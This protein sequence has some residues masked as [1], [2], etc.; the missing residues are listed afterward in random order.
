MI[1]TG[2][3]DRRCC[4]E[5]R[6]NALVPPFTS[7][8][9]RAQ[10]KV[11]SLCVLESFSRLRLSSCTNAIHRGLTSSTTAGK[12]HSVYYQRVKGRVVAR[13]RNQSIQDPSFPLFSHD[14][15]GADVSGKVGEV[16]GPHWSPFVFLGVMPVVAW[17]VL[18]TIRPDLR[19]RFLEDIQWVKSNVLPAAPVSIQEQTGSDLIQNT[20]STKDGSKAH[21]PD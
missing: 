4:H 6:Q 2:S 12:Q 14:S 3:Y 9:S 15:P 16:L 11:F 19:S 21:S 1:R 10:M 18:V 7:R 13:R 8:I 20:D 17:L 5:K